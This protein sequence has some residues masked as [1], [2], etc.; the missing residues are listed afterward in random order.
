[1]AR[2]AQTTVPL[3]TAHH[4]V[5]I[6]ENVLRKSYFPDT[7]EWDITQIGLY[8][9]ATK[10][11]QI[12]G[13]D[14][15]L[16]VGYLKISVHKLLIRKAQIK[17]LV[18]D[19]VLDK[20]YSLEFVKQDNT[21]ILIK[22]QPD[23]FTIE[24]SEHKDQDWINSVEEHRKK[25]RI[26]GYKSHEFCKFNKIDFAWISNAA[27]KGASICTINHFRGGENNKHSAMMNLNFFT[28]TNKRFKL[29]WDVTQN[30]TAKI[31]LGHANGQPKVDTRMDVKVTCTCSKITTSSDDYPEL[32]AEAVAVDTFE[33]T[34][35]NKIK[36]KEACAGKLLEQLK[37][38]GV[39]F[40]TDLVKQAQEEKDKKCAQ[41]EQDQARFAYKMTGQ[42]Q[43]DKL[44][45]TV[46]LNDDPLCTL[47]VDPAEKDRLEKIRLENVENRKTYHEI[48]VN[49]QQY[50]SKMN[51]KMVEKTA[52]NTGNTTSWQLFAGDDETEN[53]CKLRQMK[54]SIL[55]QEKHRSEKLELENRQKTELA[56]V[57]KNVEDKK[58]A[59]K[60]EITTIN[61]KPKKKVVS[62]RVLGSEI[63]PNQSEIDNTKSKHHEIDEDFL[64]QAD[65]LFTKPK[66]PKMMI[67][68]DE[69]V[70]VLAPLDPTN[71][72]S[73]AGQAKPSKMSM[74]E[75]MVNDMFRGMENEKK[76]HALVKENLKK[77]DKWL[78]M[79]SLNNWEFRS[80]P[81]HEGTIKY[82]GEGSGIGDDCEVAMMKVEYGP[83]EKIDADGCVVPDIDMKVNIVN[84][85]VTKSMVGPMPVPKGVYDDDEISYPNISDKEVVG[86][87]AYHHESGVN[88]GFQQPLF[89]KN[90]VSVF[91][92]KNR[93]AGGTKIGAGMNALN[94]LRHDHVQA[95]KNPKQS[96]NR[97][98]LPV[99][100]DTKAMRDVERVMKGG[101]FKH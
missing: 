64:A 47:R 61:I 56:S 3:T 73:S 53:E 69:P 83:D 42:K 74:N 39:I 26:I 46:K 91:K 14:I 72:T 12:T 92:D 85:T 78:V 96:F 88:K 75:V 89:K 1:M 30:K 6:L 84:G 76:R 94:Q 13:W 17:M 58:I 40:R 65:S 68:D 71:S 31:P 34:S 87:V 62:K 25:K 48:P 10:G 22:S 4:P 41:A 98:S 81:R 99:N 16:K 18:A 32:V 80:K 90:G 20:I 93:T 51:E 50:S 45:E 9:S 27:N 82:K 24:F 44:S 95:Q 37:V 67:D 11:Q 19:L 100:K 52:E 59:K 54:E 49:P 2:G 66:K 23:D 36:V 8:E 77:T 79:R 28:Q 60:R 55:L 15:K 63:D 38:K 57:L 5:K 29:K 33:F 97:N 21:D 70:M 43:I 86:T 35:M 7:P 101:K